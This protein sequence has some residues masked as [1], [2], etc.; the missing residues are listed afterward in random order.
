MKKTKSCEDQIKH[1]FYTLFQRNHTI[2]K[3]KSTARKKYKSF[4][5]FIPSPRISD[6]IS[7]QNFDVHE[8]NSLSHIYVKVHIISLVINKMFLEMNANY[9]CY[10]F[11]K[12]IRY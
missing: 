2:L 4:Q 5:Y 6:I 12:K 8:T 7:Q 11:L 1:T 3:F 10:L 9:E